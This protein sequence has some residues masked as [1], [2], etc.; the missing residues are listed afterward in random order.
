MSR[1]NISSGSV[2]EPVIG[3]SRAVKAGP[4]V[5]VSAAMGFNEAGNVMGDEDAYAQTVQ[6]LKNIAGA[7]KEAGAELKHVVRTR[8]YVTSIGDYEDVGEAPGEFFKDI[9]PAI[10]LV[11]VSNLISPDILVAIEADAYIDTE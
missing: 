8:I 11:E 10:T 9:R 2:W 6:A 7:L 3:Y 1:K 4:W 5:Q